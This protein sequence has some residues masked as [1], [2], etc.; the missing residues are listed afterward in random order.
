MSIEGILIIVGVI[1]ATIGLLVGIIA[2]N[3]QLWRIFS[4]LGI[5]CIFTSAIMNYKDQK[6]SVDTCQTKEYILSTNDSK[7]I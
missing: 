4:I 5:I 3:V 6:K 7:L 1:L 2:D